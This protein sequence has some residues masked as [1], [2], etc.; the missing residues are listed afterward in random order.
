M[1]VKGRAAAGL[2][3]LFLAACDAPTIV[4]ESPAYD[5][6][7]TLT[8]GSRGTYHWPLGRTI[9]IYVDPSTSV[10][11]AGVVSEASV[12]WRAATYFRE[13][14]TRIVSEPTA[15]DAVVHLHDA[16]PVVTI[17]SGCST[18]SAPGVTI[19]CVTGNTVIS[20]PFASGAPGSHI[21]MDV[22]VDR[23]AVGTDAEF[24]SLVAHELGH[25]FGIGGHSP[26]RD[27]LMHAAP[28]ASQ[29][30]EGDA[31]TLRFVLGRPSD[32]I[33]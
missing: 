7:V 5:P 29:P 18:G 23:T 25:V 19:I 33:L 4:A 17:P 14:D 16:A 21:K 20:L 30:S 3:L 10:D 2:A 11:L 9:A 31:R 24:L 1:A 12:R 32:L 27:D 28:T 15:A 22:S 8:D 26:D 6:S 13:F